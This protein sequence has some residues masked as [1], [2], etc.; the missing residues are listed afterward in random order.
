MNPIEMLRTLEQ[1]LKRKYICR[2]LGISD[3]AMSRWMRGHEEPGIQ[4]V[5]LIRNLYE[6]ELPCLDKRDKNDV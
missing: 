3:A 2:E 1:K 5:L 4:S 6:S